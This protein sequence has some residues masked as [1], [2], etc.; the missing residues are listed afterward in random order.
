MTVSAFSC[1][2]PI[3]SQ[4]Q[5]F[6]QQRASASTASHDQILSYRRV[7]A[8]H[9]ATSSLAYSHTCQGVFPFIGWSAGRCPDGQ[10][11]IWLLNGTTPIAEAG[12]ANPGFGWQLVSMDHFTPNG[13]ADLLFQNSTTDAMQLWE[14]NGGTS[15]VAQ[16]NLPNPG[17]GWVLQNGHPFASG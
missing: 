8:R 6:E 3:Y 5:T 14:T 1:T 4:Q 16:V 10:A 13:Q 12:L 11:G 15:I 9:L 2:L 7:P 17:G